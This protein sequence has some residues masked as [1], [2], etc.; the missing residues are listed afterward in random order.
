MAEPIVVVPIV[1]FV[2]V[3]IGYA[4]VVGIVVPAAAADDMFFGILAAVPTQPKPRR[5]DHVY[6]FFHAMI[7][8]SRRDGTLSNSP[9]KFFAM[10]NTYTQMY[11]HLVFSPLG[12]QNLILPAFEERYLFEFYD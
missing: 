8:Q 1:R 7:Y 5:G 12:R 9:L 2:F 6:R 3:V 11:A 4:A 10:A